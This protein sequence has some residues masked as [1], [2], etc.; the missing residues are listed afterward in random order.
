[1]KLL[2]KYFLPVLLLFSLKS[3]AQSCL[4]SH[5]KFDGNA[6]DSKGTNHGTNNGASLTSDRFGTPNSAYLFNASQSDYIAIPFSAFALPNYSYSLWIKLNSLPASG[7]S[8]IF[9]SVGGTGGDQNMQIE[10]AQNN[11]SLGILTGFSLTTYNGN[12]N[13][14]MGNAAGV[15]PS[16]NKWYHVVCTRDTNLIKVYV[17][18]C[19][20]AVSASSGGALPYYGSSNQA[21]T[22]G[23][24]NNLS[25]YVD[26]VI[27]DVKIFGCA[28]T[29][30]EIY[31]LYQPNRTFTVTKDTT[32]CAK[33]LSGYQLKASPK[34]CSY[35]WIDVKNRKVTLGV[36]STLT[37]NLNKTT[38]FRVF[39][40]LND[41]ATV[42]IKFSSLKQSLGK[43]TSFCPLFSHTLNAGNSGQKYL[44]NNGDSTQSLNINSFGTYYVKI[45]DSGGCVV[46]D[47]INVTQKTSDKISL[48]NDTTICGSFTLILDPKLNALKYL[49]SNGDTTKTLMV[50]QAGL[51]TLKATQ[52]NLCVS[53]DTLLISSASFPKVNL[54]NDTTICGP[55]NLTLL[56]GN[57]TN[58]YLWNTSDT[59]NSISINQ[60]GTYYVQV[61]NQYKCKAFDT[62]RIYQKKLPRLFLGNDTTYCN[63]FSRLLTACDSALTYNW[64]TGASS[65][66]ILVNS[67]G[68][69]SVRASFGKDCDLFDTITIK[70]VSAQKINLG[71]DTTI[72]KGASLV[73]SNQVP[74]S[75][76]VW[77]GSTT[78]NSLNI[79]SSGTYYVKLTDSNNCVS[80][81]T[82]VVNVSQGPLSRFTTN[83]TLIPLNSGIV[84]LTNFA[85]NFNKLYYKFGD[86]NSTDSLNPWYRY[87]KEGFFNIRQIVFD[88]FGCKD[89]SE[90]TI[91]IYDD[92]R[93]YV[94]GAFT[95]N[96]DGTNDVFKPVFNGVIADD[97]EFL[98]FNRWGEMI[99]KSNDLNLGWDGSYKGDAVNTDVFMYII[100]LRTSRRILHTFSGTFLIV[101]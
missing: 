96:E 9:L 6:N 25:K 66:S 11:A 48:G 76:A 53:E 36:D 31:N 80:N 16:T 43:D 19:L 65:N 101:R 67:G 95:P 83:Q 14:R 56:A 70:Q 10:N 88:S 78:T 98:I 17:N 71:R 12:S 5:Y 81:D 24:R 57:S 44:W 86:G 92:F 59:N 52:A 72:C 85:A 13:T 41:S 68:P 74:K 69:Y 97:Y 37:V 33:S 62:I 93:I 27:D 15:M 29:A 28:L 4:V 35:K 90:I 23:C 47:T 61:T 20:A 21:A 54:G 73:L 87:K 63:S 89:S 45:T 91:T 2:F 7:S 100:K 49:W 82:I 79:N 26:A 38:T 60:L 39:N 1:M 40:H 94:P 55:I 77:N 18:G 75:I 30:Q 22:I 3:Y 84:K 99:F 58:R 64:N 51:Y 46:S 34:Y 32:I 8:Y 42:T 50:N